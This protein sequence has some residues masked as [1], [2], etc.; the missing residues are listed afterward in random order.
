MLGPQYQ[1]GAWG[2]LKYWAPPPWV[3]KISKLKLGLFCLLFYPPSG[4]F[5][6][7]ISFFLVMAPLII[8]LSNSWSVAFQLQLDCIKS[9]SSSYLFIICWSK[10]LL[11]CWILCFHCQAQSQLQSTSTPVGAEFSLIP[12]LSN[13]LTTRR[14]SSFKSRKKQFLLE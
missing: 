6:K 3:F 5:S 2:F 9:R 13:Y 12:N 4:N 7:I 14:N 10:L 8:C 1:S 11:N